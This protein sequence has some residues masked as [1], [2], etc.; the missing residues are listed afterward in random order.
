MQVF[1]L[2]KEGRQKEALQLQW[3]LSLAEGCTKGGVAS[4]KFAAAVTTA[5]RAGIEGAVGL[6]KPRAPYEEPDEGV[7][8][9][10][11]DMVGSLRG[12]EDS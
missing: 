3:R 9:R 1:E 8:K 4:I 5:E 2:W 12:L 6:L 10:I 11:S 7:K